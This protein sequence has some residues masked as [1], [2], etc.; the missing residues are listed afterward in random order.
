MDQLAW[1][2]WDNLDSVLRLMTAIGSLVAA[3]ASLLL[4]YRSRER[5]PDIIARTQNLELAIK[6]TSPELVSRTVGF[7][8]PPDPARWLVYEVRLA[9]SRHNWLAVPGEE[10]RNHEGGVVLGYFRC[11]DWTDRIRY[12]PPVSK[13]LVLLHPDAPPYPTLFFRVRLRSHSYF[14]TKRRVKVLST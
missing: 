6:S 3:G 12:E 8:L 11:G 14:R 2:S 10:G 13:G 7:H 5:A 1:L 4:L 9:K